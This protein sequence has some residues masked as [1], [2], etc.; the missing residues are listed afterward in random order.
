[1]PNAWEAGFL[2]RFAHA[3]VVGG[4]PSESE[5]PLALGGAGTVSAESFDGMQYRRDIGKRAVTR[6]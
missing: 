4:K 5:R 6:P 2:G 3:F 1:M